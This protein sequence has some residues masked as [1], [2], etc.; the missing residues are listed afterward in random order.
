MSK[1]TKLKN[2]QMLSYIYICIKISKIKTQVSTY[3]IAFT[4]RGQLPCLHTLCQGAIGQKVEHLHFDKNSEAIY[5]F[6]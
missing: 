1:L 3:S 5:F 4:F 6:Q 2:N